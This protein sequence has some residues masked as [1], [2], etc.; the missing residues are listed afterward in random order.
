M[1]ARAT[2]L[3]VVM[4]LRR[5]HAAHAARLDPDRQAALRREIT[6]L[7]RAYFGP[8]G[9]EAQRPDVEAV[10]KQWASLIE[11]KA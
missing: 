4:T 1:P 11:S 5:L 10:L 9:P 3:N 6:E 7:E 8:A 2:P